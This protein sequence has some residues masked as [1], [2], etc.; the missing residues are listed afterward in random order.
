VKLGIFTD[1]HYSTAELTC[2]NRYNS[3]S[4]EKIRRAYERFK[5]EGCELVI[6]LGD[7]IDKEID[8][9]AEVDNL[10]RIASLISEY[11]I[12]TR[13]VMGNHDA[14]AFEV[15]EFYAVL[16][17]K[18]RPQNILT[19]GLNL[20]FL[21]ACHFKSGVHYGPGDNNWTDT[22]FPYYE[23]LDAL[24]SSIC[25]ECYIFVHQNIDPFVR[26]DHRLYNDTELREVF[27]RNGNVKTVF[28]GHYHQGKESEYNGIHYITY[29]AMCTNENAYFIVEV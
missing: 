29:P 1:S 26:E 10:A 19:D 12:D 23:K 15:D 24:L 11:G 3:R 27:E 21:D 18:L 5:A 25:G 8:H 17:E 13:V 2:G 28:Q 6:C 20:I 4:L 9:S 22:F 14:F 16:G 7:L